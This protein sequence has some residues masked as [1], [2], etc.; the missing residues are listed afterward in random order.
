MRLAQLFLLFIFLFSVVDLYGQ[1]DI[2]YSSDGR[3][4]LKRRL[5]IQNC[6]VSLGKTKLDKAALSMCECRTNLFDRSFT[7]KQFRRHTK[8]G[9]IDLNALVEEDTAIAKKMADCFYG[10]SVI[11]AAG[12]EENFVAQCVKSIQK[13]AQK[14]LDTARLK[15]FCICQRELIATKKLTDSQLDAVENPNSLLYYEML[16]KCGDPFAEQEGIQNWNASFVKDITGPEIDTVT[17]LNI[18]GMTYVKLK[19]GSL[20]QIWLFDTGASDFLITK[21]M[22]KTLKAENIMTDANYLGIGEYE[23]ANGAVE[24]CRKYKINN[25]KVGDFSVDNVIVAVSEKAKKII[26]GKALFNKFSSWTLNNEQN[27]LILRK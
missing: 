10:Q 2:L 15:S 20:L 16:Y 27:K 12:N 22:E 26:A 4:V 1:D 13:N 18:A 6:L 11:I 9:I 24:K 23:M 3:S 25:L 17:T 21:D 7:M 8:K 14:T 19:I 5:L